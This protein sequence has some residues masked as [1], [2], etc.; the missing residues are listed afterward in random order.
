[1]KFLCRFPIAIAITIASSGTN[2]AQAAVQYTLGTILPWISKNSTSVDL[3]TA[4]NG[5]YYLSDRTNAV[6]H[7]VD[8]AS[9][10]ETGQI[11]GFKGATVVN[12]TVDKPTLGPNGLL[13]IPGRNELYIGDG[14]GSVKV[15][16]LSS[17]TVVD[18]IPR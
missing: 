12:G 10:T 8:L 4:V 17:N 6:V 13:Y 3:G 14:D 1:M 15:V 18:T 2:Q 9:S 16:D 7:I 11:T 5:T